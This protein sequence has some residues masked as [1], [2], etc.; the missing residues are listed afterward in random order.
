MASA[1]LTQAH[2]VCP[3]AAQPIVPATPQTRVVRTCANLKTD[4]LPTD[5]GT[6]GQ[7]V[8]VQFINAGYIGREAAW[9]ASVEEW[10]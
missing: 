6:A 5:H 10:P 4:L 9:R 8:D 3:Y 7:D 2:N 1:L